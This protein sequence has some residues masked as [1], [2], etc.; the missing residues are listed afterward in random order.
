MKEP[1]WKERCAVCSPSAGCLWKSSWWTIGP[2]TALAK[3]C[4]GSRHGCARADRVRVDALPDGWLGK[5]HACHV[6]ASA[7]TGEW[8]LFTDAD[9]WLKPDV[10]ARALRVADREAVDHITLTPGVVPRPGC[11]G[12]ASGV[13]DQIGKLVAGVNRD[14]AGAYLGMGAFNLVRATAYRDAAVTKPCV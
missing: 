10:I 2:L 4:S 5:C 9:C 13:S 3:S 7:A 1:G 12:V 11:R 6:G 14:R 8:I